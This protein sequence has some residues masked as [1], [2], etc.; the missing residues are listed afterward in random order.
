MRTCASFRCCV[1][2][3]SLPRRSISA[4]TPWPY[5]HQRVA[6]AHCVAE[7][8][9]ET[10]RNRFGW[11]LAVMALLLL[12]G[13][14]SAQGGKRGGVPTTKSLDLAAEKAET[15][16]LSNLADL[17]AKYEDAGEL[18]K[19]SDMLRG[20]L[21]IKP[22]AEV[23][24]AK[25]KK[26]EETV[27]KENVHTLEIDPGSG[28]IAAGILVSKDKPVRIEAEGSYKFIANDVLTPMGYPGDDLLRGVV[29]GVP[30][31]A[32][33]AV[34]GSSSDSGSSRRPPKDLPKPMFIGSQKELTPKESG[35]LLFRMNVPDGSKCTGKIKVKVTGNIAV[36]PR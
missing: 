28:W 12:P 14:A 23:V 21:R 25:L 10:Q 3:G 24:K 16:Y 2:S 1:P 26:F 36:M 27:F 5:F 6:G 8:P 13:L 11:C 34:V 9:Q 18:Q 30:T 33:M 22:D 32:L 29:E 7:P 31:G 20:I 15:D 35:P 19:A 17:A 4:S